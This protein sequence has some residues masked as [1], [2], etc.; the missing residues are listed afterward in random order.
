[1]KKIYVFMVHLPSI[2]NK[3]SYI[4]TGFKYT[5]ISICL[6]NEFKKFYAFQVKNIRTPLVGGFMQENESFFFQA[7]NVTSLEE[8]V[9]ELPVTDEEYIK[10]SNYVT[11]IKEDKE[12]IFNYVSSLFMFLVGGIKVYKAFHCCEF[13]CEVLNNIDSIEFPKKIYKMHPKD[14]YKSLLKFEH[15]KKTI[16]INDYEFDDNN[17]FFKQLKAISVIK[18]SYY[19]VT[20][21]IIR[22]ILK[23]PRKNYNYCKLN[24]DDSDVWLSN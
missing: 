8:L 12:Y 7:K 2:A 5:H 19:S 23:R 22:A 15:Y 3:C 1:M 18:K 13:A 17:I 24:Y 16:N 21:C 6:D 11:S 14:L 10:V 20:E 9:F 4:F